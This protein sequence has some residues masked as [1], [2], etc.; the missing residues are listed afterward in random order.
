MSTVKIATLQRQ[1]RLLE[2]EVERERLF[3]QHDSKRSGAGPMTVWGR[4]Q[5]AKGE[6]YSGPF[7]TYEDGTMFQVGKAKPTSLRQ[8]YRGDWSG[9]K[10]M[11]EALTLLDRQAE[12]LVP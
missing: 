3:A 10:E 6:S 11:T 7:S 12:D 4:D 8:G 9:I 1:I 5:W 2:M